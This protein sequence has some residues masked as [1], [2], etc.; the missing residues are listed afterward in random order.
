ME[1]GND[2]IKIGH[3]YIDI[4]MSKCAFLMRHESSLFE[5]VIKPKNDKLKYVYLPCG[6][7]EAEDIVCKINE[8]IFLYG[9]NGTV[10]KGDDIISEVLLTRVKDAIK[11]TH[12]VNALHGS[13][14]YYIGE[15][16]TMSMGEIEDINQL[17]APTVKKLKR[18]LLGLGLGFNMVIPGLDE[19]IQARKDH[20]FYIASL[21]I[22]KQ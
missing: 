6:E 9:K 20:D 11:K 16:V 14:I 13:E 19:A 12:L 3:I 22:D 8:A 15:I 7:D 17:G 10:K 21:D 18:F 1:L 4:S 5:A 2:I